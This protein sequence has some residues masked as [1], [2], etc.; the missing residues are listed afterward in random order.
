MKQ[1]DAIAPD[2]RFGLLQATALNMS[3]MLG[4]GP[5][6]TIPALMATMGGP[7]SMLGWGVA[8]I[9]AL[10]D[11]LVWSEL[12]AALQKSGGSYVYLREGYGREK[13]GRFMGFLFIW[14]FILSGPLELATAYVGVAQYLQSLWPQ[15]SELARLSAGAVVGLMMIVLLYRRIESIGSIMMTLWAGVLLAMAVVI[16]TGVR[17]FDAKLAFDFP[18]DAWSFDVTKWV[19]LGAAA[20][21]GMYDYLGY[22]DICF[23]GDEVKQPGRVIPR[24]VMLSLVLVALIYFAVNLSIIG[25]VPWRE[26]VST[27]G[28]SEPV[29]TIMMTKVY[30]SGF[31]QLFTLLVLWTMVACCFAMLLGYSR[32]PYAAARDGSFFKVFGRLHASLGFP[33]VSLIV[34]GVVSAAAT[35]VKLGTLI[36]ALLTTRIVVQ[37]AGQIGALVLLRRMKPELERP[38]RM[39]LYPLPALLA[40]AGW[41]YLLVT[42]DRTLVGYGM[43]ALL[44][45]ALAFLAWSW[46]MRTW[47]FLKVKDA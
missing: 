28:V 20:R 43:A 36:D 39:W 16:W 33:H 19:A 30:G 18:A 14:Q 17:N 8:L 35:F 24:A 25:V 38:F 6:I 32:I 3:N 9:L 7:Q 13:W 10:A 26:L 41:T 34:I 37:F 2:R 27:E 21:I 40:L 31:A 22:Y 1:A 45:G 5:F 42:T 15:S 44:A 23:I 29:V 47:P 4:A 12:G 11:G 46:K